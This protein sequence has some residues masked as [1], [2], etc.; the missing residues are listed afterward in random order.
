MNDGTCRK[1]AASTASRSPGN[2]SNSAGSAVSASS[3]GQ[4]GADAAV[5]ADPERQVVVGAARRVEAGP[6]PARSARDPAPR[7]RTS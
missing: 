1:L 5:H 3:A 4:R 7:R 6:R 2:R